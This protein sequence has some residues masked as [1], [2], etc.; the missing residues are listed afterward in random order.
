MIDLINWV[1]T[2]FIDTQ[3]CK[4]LTQ[5]DMKESNICASTMSVSC[6]NPVH[7]LCLSVLLKCFAYLCF[8]VHV[9]TFEFRFTFISMFMR[10]KSALIL[11]HFHR[12]V[13]SLG[14]LCTLCIL[15]FFEGLMYF[16]F[17]S[18]LCVAVSFV[19]TFR[20]TLQWYQEQFITFLGWS[21]SPC[22]LPPWG[23]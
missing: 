8:K 22:W 18:A 15:L 9:L 12:C 10:P 4:E 20:I 17:M 19:L 23:W 6:C 2:Y 13:G 21:G 1:Q 11:Y 3:I 14:L 16:L 7:V 5:L